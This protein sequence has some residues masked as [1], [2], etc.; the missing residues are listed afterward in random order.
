MQAWIDTHMKSIYMSKIEKYDVTYTLIL[1]IKIQNNNWRVPKS[2]RLIQNDLSFWIISIYSLYF[3]IIDSS[4]VLY[5]YLCANYFAKC[6]TKWFRN[7]NAVGQSLM[8]PY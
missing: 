2:I 8:L 6:A 7:T 4:I 1:T 5:T 3:S